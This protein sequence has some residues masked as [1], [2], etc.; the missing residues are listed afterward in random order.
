MPDFLS[1]DCAKCLR[2]GGGQELIQ[3][4][5]SLKSPETVARELWARDAAAKEHPCARRRLLVLDRDAA[6]EVEAPG[7][8]EIN[9]SQKSF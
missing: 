3:V 7:P 2:L 9:Y 6:G 8:G 4:C 1:A 5:A